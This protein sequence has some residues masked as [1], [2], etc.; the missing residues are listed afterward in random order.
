MVAARHLV[1]R[2][3]DVE[4]V[5]SAPQAMTEVPAHQL[6]IQ[7]RMSVPVVTA[8]RVPALVLDAVLGY[9][10]SGDPHGRAAELI[11]WANA[12]DA[13]VLALDSPSGPPRATVWS[14]PSGEPTQ[15]CTRRREQVAAGSW[16][17]TESARPAAAE[18]MAQG[19]RGTPKRRSMVAGSPGHASSNT[20]TGTCLAA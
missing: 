5:L 9:S 14:M 4:V 17:P 18:T 11:R 13:P 12:C 3:V 20:S 6:D 2:G 8:P 1:N 19:L 15:P 10:I 7:R 16:W